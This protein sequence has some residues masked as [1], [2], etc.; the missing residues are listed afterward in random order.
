MASRSCLLWIVVIVIALPLAWIVFNLVLN[1][2]VGL[3]R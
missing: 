2:A 3:G 1:F